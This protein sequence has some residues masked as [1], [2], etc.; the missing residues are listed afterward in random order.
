[1]HAATTTATII[2]KVLTGFSTGWNAL[3][4]A[5]QVSKVDV[6]GLLTEA[7]AQ[8]NI[9]TEVHILQLLVYHSHT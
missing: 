1:M 7:E 9:H 8:V 5:A 4:L 6:V 2:N 3:H